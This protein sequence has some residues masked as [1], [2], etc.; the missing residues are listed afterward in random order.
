M[1]KAALGIYA[2]LAI[3]ATIMALG[4]CRA[5]ARG[6]RLSERALAELEVNSQASANVSHDTGAKRAQDTQL[7][8]RPMP[9]C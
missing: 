6:D 9:V 8:R 3:P 4:L 1:L 7:K 2:A 5:A